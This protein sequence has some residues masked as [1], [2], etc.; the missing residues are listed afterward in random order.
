MSGGCRVRL[1][2]TDW[3]AQGD[4]EMGLHTARFVTASKM[5][6]SIACNEP[7]SHT[8]Y[9]PVCALYTSYITISPVLVAI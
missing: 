7:Q 9:I 2:Y 6:R 5:Q 4:L 1:A 8:F 3:Q